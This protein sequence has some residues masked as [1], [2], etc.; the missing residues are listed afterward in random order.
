[1]SGVSPALHVYF[2]GEKRLGI[3][4]AVFGIVLCMAAWS[5]YRAQTGPIGFWLGIPLLVIG[6]G[7]GAGGIVFSMKTDAQVASLVARL[8]SAPAAAVSDELVRMARVNANWPRL[9]LTWALLTL[10]AMGLL[11]FGKR[12]ATSG[13]GLALMLL[14]TS[15][16][17]VDVFAEKRALIYTSAL[18]AAEQPE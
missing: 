15:L 2:A 16:F 5:A 11:L 17:F 6:L 7:L 9:K 1:M 18:E 3:S 4:L 14:T 12:D 10:V 13:V 8:E